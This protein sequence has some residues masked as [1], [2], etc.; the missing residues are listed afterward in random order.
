MM[1]R[2]MN[3]RASLKRFPFIA[4]LR[5]IREQEAYEACAILLEAGF[6]IVEI[7]L[8]SPDP[9]KSLRIMVDNFGSDALI[10]AGTVVSVPEVERVQQAGGRLVVC[11]NCNEQVIRRARALDLVCLPGVMTPTEAFTALYAGA[12]GLKLFPAEIISAQGIK[13][14]SAVLPPETIMIPVGGIDAANWRTFQEMGA[15]GFGLGSSLY[16]AGMSME[17]LK[18]KAQSFNQRRI[19]AERK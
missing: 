15:A 2:G 11:P 4:I 18:A 17:E 19:S 10:G 16:R 7:P 13:A 6:E 5:G 12:D 14:M 3:L 1:D 8:N 9:F